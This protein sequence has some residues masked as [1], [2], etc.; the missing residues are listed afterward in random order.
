MVICRR[1]VQAH[2]GLES[3]KNQVSVGAQSG[4]SPGQK[5][6]LGHSQ[7]KLVGAKSW[8]SR[9]TVGVKLS[10]MLVVSHQISNQKP[11][12]SRGRVGKQSGHSRGT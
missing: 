11:S 10:D 7:G 9:G 3:G 5:A 1:T 12:I 4:Q 2:S 6:Q 8:H